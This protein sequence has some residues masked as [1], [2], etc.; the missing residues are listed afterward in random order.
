MRKRCI[1]V[2]L[3]LLAAA[4][5]TRALTVSQL[6]SVANITDLH[7]RPD[8][9]EVA[10]AVAT[11]DSS[12]RAWNADVWRV[13]VGSGKARRVTDGPAWDDSPRWSPDGS[14]RLAYLSDAGGKNQVFLAGDEAAARP[15]TAAANGVAVFEWSPDGRR[16]AYLSPGGESEASRLRRENGADVRIEDE[17]TPPATVHVVVVDTGQDRARDVPGAVDVTTLDWSPDGARL[18]ITVQSLP[19][20]IGFFYG[21]DIAVLDVESGVV[22]P[23]VTRD[24]MDYNPRWSPDGRSLAFLSHDGVKDWIGCCYLCVVPADGSGKARNISPGFNERDYGAEYQWAAD[25]KHVYLVAPAGVTRHLY[26]IDV[27]NADTRRVSGGVAV[28]GRFSFSSDGSSAAFLRTTTS[29]PAEVFVSALEPFQPRA[30][31]TLNASVAGAVSADHEVVRWKSFDGTTV[32]GILVAPRKRTGALPLVTVIHGGPSTPCMAAFSVQAGVPGWP[33]G[34]FVAHTMVARG[35]AVFFPNFRGTTG[36][37][38]EFLRAN[39]GDWGGGDFKD[40]MTGI[41]MLVERGVADPGRLAIVGWSYGGTLTSFAIGQTPRFR[42]AVVGAG[43][44]DHLSQYGTTDIPPLIETYM[45]GTP[46]KVPDTY[47]RC[48]SMT[49]A[50]QVSTPTLLCYGEHDA[51]VP[52]SQG[53]EFY[54]I[55]RARGVPAELVIYPR[56]GHFIFEPALEA[57]FQQR[58][59][60]WL[61][62]WLRAE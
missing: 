5:E 54:R 10:Y 58:M 45:G 35:Y 31:T 3:V 4:G 14:G 36:Y 18:A 44:T 34:E 15:L 26:A 17:A 22:T 1:A 25:S 8:G 57:D 48:S 50:S 51:R 16:I 23:V 55:L 39:V 56:S 19:A 21:S 61:D 28:F 37:G 52:P 11:L 33:Q 53:R 27:A 46:W 41:D 62:R 9:T 20:T 12:G 47:R 60:D 38:R 59:L 42:A 2:T 29:E 40:V 24:G 49:F 43:V 13:D 7:M 32:E 30:L 6:M